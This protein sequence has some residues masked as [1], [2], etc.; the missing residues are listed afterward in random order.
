[1]LVAGAFTISHTKCLKRGLLEFFVWNFAEA[2]WSVTGAFWSQS[3]PAEVNIFLNPV[4]KRFGE[5]LFGYFVYL[6][7]LYII[8]IIICCWAFFL[9]NNLRCSVLL[10]SMECIWRFSQIDRLAKSLPIEHRELRVVLAHLSTLNIR[11]KFFAGP[12]GKAQDL[13]PLGHGSY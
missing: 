9:A 6:H 11:W 8:I 5:I 12:S 13:R 2:F 4:P 7:I 1:M 10:N 3:A